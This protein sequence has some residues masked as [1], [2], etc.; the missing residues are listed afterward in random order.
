M[1]NAFFS[2]ATGGLFGNAWWLVLG[3]FLVMAHFTLMSVT[4]YLH[5]C[6]AHRAVDLH[7]QWLGT[8]RFRDDLLAL[9]LRYLQIDVP[10]TTH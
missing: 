9:L 1:D 8:Q 2:W 5:R 10:T 7:P 4:I 6:Q 3:A